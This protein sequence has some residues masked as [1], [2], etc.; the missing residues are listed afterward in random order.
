MALTI[1]KL[2]A[3]VGVSRDTIRYYE[4]SG[5]LPPAHRDPNGYRL[6]EAQEADRLRFIRGARRLGLKLR[7]IRDLLIVRDRGLC[8]CGHTSA[9]IR[10]RLAELDA[11]LKRLE[12]LRHELVALSKH[13]PFGVRNG[14]GWPCERE[15][16]QLGK[17]GETE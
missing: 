11:D 1:S 12:A 2:A 15:F 9:L 10:D 3:A 8:P 6:Y 13:V 5:L 16:I 17:G 14:D 7:D 4:R